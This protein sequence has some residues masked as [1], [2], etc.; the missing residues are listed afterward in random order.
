MAEAAEGV[1]WAGLGVLVVAAT[2]GLVVV[3]ARAAARVAGLVELLEAPGAVSEGVVVREVAVAVRAVARAVVTVE[4]ARV[5]VMEEQAAGA[6]AMA[7]G[8]HRKSQSLRFFP[9]CPLTT[10]WCHQR[11]SANLVDQRGCSKPKTRKNILR[12][13]FGEQSGGRRSPR[14]RYQTN[15]QHPQHRSRQRSLG[16]CSTGS[17]RSAPPSPAYR[18]VP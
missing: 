2:A 6:A 8:S 5:A 13:T 16:G 11:T 17:R 10:P 7:T 18:S 4:V 1:A 12:K 9:V 14:M 15:N 3:A